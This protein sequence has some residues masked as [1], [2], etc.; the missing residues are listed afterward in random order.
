MKSYVLLKVANVINTTLDDLFPLSEWPNLDIIAEPGRFY[1][2]SA[3]TL[4]TNVIAK[5]DV[6]KDINTIAVDNSSKGMYYASLFKYSL[7]GPISNTII[8]Y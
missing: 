3:F 8:F 2:A 6:S 4:A 5:R 7:D 1:A